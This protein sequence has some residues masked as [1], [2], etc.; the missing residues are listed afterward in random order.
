MS[1]FHDN[2]NVDA[3]VD[4]SL[5]SSMGLPVIYIDIVGQCLRSDGCHESG[6]GLT[7]RVV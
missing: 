3:L 7:K 1:F 2:N 5:I 6:M 4:E